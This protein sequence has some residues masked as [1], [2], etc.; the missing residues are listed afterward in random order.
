[1]S[2]V[3]NY[4][5]L[6]VRFSSNNSNYLGRQFGDKKILIDHF[7]KEIEIELYIRHHLEDLNI[8][9]KFLYIMKEIITEL[10][11]RIH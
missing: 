10:D 2:G 6:L 5:K 11:L 4:N 3:D 8:K 1:M 7:I 9:L